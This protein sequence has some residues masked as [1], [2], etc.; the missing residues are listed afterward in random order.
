MAAF[1]EAQ[2]GDP[3]AVYDTGLLPKAGIVTD[4]LSDRTGYLSH[5]D[6]SEIGICSLILGG[7]R[8]TKESAIDLSV[9]LILRKKVGD[10]VREG[11]VL[12]QIH[13]NDPQKQEEAVKRFLAACHFADQAP[14][15]RALIRTIIH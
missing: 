11:D 10:Y 5:M 1:V 15:K 3:R 12:A 2:G 9:G 13:A 14:E 4:I 6:C 7:G 8:E